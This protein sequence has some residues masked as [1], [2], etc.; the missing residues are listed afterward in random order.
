MVRTPLKSITETSGPIV[1]LAAALALVHGC[2]AL[3][4]WGIYPVP[5]PGW[6][7]ALLW[8]WGWG[9][10][11]GLGEGCITVHH[12]SGCTHTFHGYDNPVEIA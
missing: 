5:W 7:G 3:C 4:G 12:G 10:H 2:F 6:V 9:T 1:L 11:Y 8:V